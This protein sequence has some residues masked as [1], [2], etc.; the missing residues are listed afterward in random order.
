ME[1]GHQY[2]EYCSFDYQLHPVDVHGGVALSIAHAGSRYFTNLV[3][4]MDPAVV[5]TWGFLDYMG[6]AWGHGAR[7]AARLCVVYG[8]F[9]WKAIGIWRWLTHAAT[10]AARRARHRDKL[11]V[12]AAHYRIAE[13]KVRALDALRVVPV[14]KRLRKTLQTLFLDRIAVIAVGLL[15]TPLVL[16]VARG[17]FRPRASRV[18]WRSGWRWRGCWGATTWWRRTRR[19]GACPRPSAPSCAR[20]SSSSA[21][22]TWPKRFRCAAAAPT[23]TPARGPTRTWPARSPTWW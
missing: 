21:T 1:H 10:D 18:W 19:C 14:I 5:E 15:A 2:D 4:S 17:W 13:D 16:V 7:A 9:A 8:V 11:R 22:R 20:P 6:W 23:S 12:M 3:P